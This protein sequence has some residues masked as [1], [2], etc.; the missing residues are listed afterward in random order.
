MFRNYIKVAWRNIVRNPFHAAVNIFGCAVGIAFV[1]IIGAYVWSQLEVNRN[2]RDAGRQYIITSKWKMPDE[3]YDFTTSGELPR[4]LAREYLGL[5]ARYFRWD[6]ITSDVSKG[7]RAFREDIAICDSTLLDMYGFTLLQGNPATALDQPFSVV[8]TREMALKYFGKARV[9]GQT[10]TIAGFTGTKHDFL[11]TGVLAPYGK[12]SVTD[13]IEGAPN[14]FFVSVSNLSFFGRNMNWGNPHI[15]GYLELQKGVTPQA[16]TGPLERLIREH[17]PAQF[18]TDLTPSLV[19]LTDYYPDANHGVVKK[20]VFALSGVALFILAMAF[21]NF[22]N[23]SVSRATSRMR[24]IGIRK[25]LGGEKRQLII[26]FLT[27]STVIVLAATLAG[28]G[29]YVLTRNLFSDISGQTLPVLQDFPAWFLLFPPAFILVTGVV[30]G[31]YPAFILSSFGTVESLKGKKVPE[32]GHALVRRSL[33]AFQFITAIVAIT[34]AIIISKQ[35]NFFLHSDLGFDKDLIVSAQLPRNWTR[36]GVDHMESVRDQ[37]AAIP[38]VKAVSLS[39]EIP[40]GNNSNELPILC[41]GSDSARAVA[42]EI[43][44][45]DEKFLSLYRIPLL[46]GTP[47]E[48][49]RRDSLEVILNETAVHALG[50]NDP[51]RA[52]GGQVKIAGNPE[53]YTVKG[54]IRDFHFGS[55]ESRIAPVIMFHLEYDFIYRFL[56]FKIAGPDI[57]A[58][59]EAIRHAWRRLLPGAPFEYRFMDETLAKMYQSELQL[60]KA[61]YVA[62]TLAL[63]IVLLGVIGMISAGIQK[64]QREIGIRKILGASVPGIIVL[65]LGEFLQVLIP[66][67]AVGCPLAYWIMHRWLQDYAYRIALTPWP[68][69]VAVTVLGLVTVL[70]IVLQTLKTA[71]SNPVNALRTE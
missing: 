49:H 62:T 64:R 3:G 4:T 48:G 30:A 8:I 20:M 45:D 47:F 58:S 70:L 71:V 46:A 55:M 9:V 29:V 38:A 16:L 11:V 12:N 63:V 24:E 42:A 65:F 19:S 17:A 50:W 21:I 59:V 37:F 51:S 41:P 31:I 44:E 10:L 60:K 7:D 23:L 34:G 6:G 40:D 2:L 28:G 5:V 15:A 27:E 35:V 36:E 33:T 68:F 54:V 43:L 1:L 13:L 53:V 32:L 67:A 52:I 26:Q 61:S 14:H 25:V 22:V 18:A 39:F 57:P 69:L 56:S 66:G